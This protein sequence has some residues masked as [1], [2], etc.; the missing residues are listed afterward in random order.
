[1]RMKLIIPA[2]AH[3]LATT[4]AAPAYASIPGRIRSGYSA[5]PIPAPPTNP[6]ISRTYCS[7]AKLSNP[8]YNDG[9]VPEPI[10]DHSR[11]GGVDPNIRPS[12]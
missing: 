2:M 6:G 4:L 11:T 1:M 10:F 12:N 8:F 9:W 7:G 3:T 5:R